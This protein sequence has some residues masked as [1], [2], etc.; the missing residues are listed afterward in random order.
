MLMSGYRNLTN[1]EEN[2]MI[3]FKDFRFPL[4]ETKILIESCESSY[5]SKYYDILFIDAIKVLNNEHLFDKQQKEIFRL[6]FLN[7]L[8]FGYDYG[9]NYSEHFIRNSSFSDN[10]M[11]HK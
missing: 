8:E 7:F 5:Y 10:K 6:R 9:Y 4:S 2:C 1:E 11:R 3:F